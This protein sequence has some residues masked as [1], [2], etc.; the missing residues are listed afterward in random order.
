[1]NFYVHQD[2]VVQVE[3]KEI[4]GV[5]LEK[6]GHGSYPAWWVQCGIDVNL[7]YEYD[8]NRWNDKWAKVC[9]CGSD[10]LYHPGHSHFCPK[11][12]RWIT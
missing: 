10:K 7:F 1:M 12:D 2:I 11:F 5:L 3:G 9:E 8:L 4:P 6:Y